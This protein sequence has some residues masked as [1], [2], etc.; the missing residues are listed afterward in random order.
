VAVFMVEDQA[1]MAADASALVEKLR[2]YVRPL[3]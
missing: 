3:S 1:P 2:P